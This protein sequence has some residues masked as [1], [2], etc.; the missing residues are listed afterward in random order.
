MQWSLVLSLALTA[1]D[2]GHLDPHPFKRALCKGLVRFATTLHY[3]IS[4]GHST[5]T[6]AASSPFCLVVS[7]AMIAP[8]SGRHK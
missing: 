4:C 6:V 3:S 2:L 7:R 5:Q 8:A 1:V